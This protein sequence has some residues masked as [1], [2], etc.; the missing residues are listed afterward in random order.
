MGT[1]AESAHPSAPDPHALWPPLARRELLL[2][3]TL[4]LAGLALRAYNVT[5]VGLDHFDE[6]A[7]AYNAVG[8][9]YPGGPRF[10]YLHHKNLS[11]PG[12]Y[13]LIALAYRV[14]GGPSD[15][16]AILPN[17]LLGTLTIPLL[18]AFARRWFG[19]AAGLAAG[20]LVALNEFH[21]RLSRMALTDVAFGLA[22][23]LA[24]ACLAEAVKR[25]SIAWAL[26]AGAATGAAWNTKYHGWLALAVGGAAYALYAWQ[27]RRPPGSHARA[28]LPLG[29]AAGAAGLS[30]LPWALL[31]ELRFGGYRELAARQAR[32][33]SLD[34]LPNA[35][36]QLESQLYFEGGW[37]RASV[38]VALLGALLA[39]SRR[40]ADRRRFPW[41]LALCAASAWIGAA[42]VALLLG[43]LALPGILRRGAPYAHWVLASLF[44]GWLI[45][46]PF[47]H[48]YPRLALPLL[49]ASFLLAGRWM[50]GAAADAPEA[51]R[52]GWRP[53]TLA[54]AGAL[55]AGL[56]W[57]SAAG[58]ERTP[59]DAARDKPRVAARL[60]AELP[61]D[62]RV[63]VVSD[64]ALLFYLHTSGRGRA[65]MDF[66]ERLPPDHDPAKI[67]TYVVEGYQAQ[68]NTLLFRNLHRPDARLV[69]EAR[70]EAGASE[71]VVLDALGPIRGR[72]FL[73]DPD[74]RFEVRLHRYE[75]S[76]APQ[77]APGPAL[78]RA[79]A[80]GTPP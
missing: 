29:I 45:L 41:A 57:P 38:F 35:W 6:G 52:G 7:Y 26:A 22:F 8:L 33:L 18:W 28:L 24:V 60:D 17:V 63:I 10:L 21:V 59:W 31:V 43:L 4:L 56:L 65:V 80:A 12:Y 20:A 9:A 3:A 71:M 69:L 79:G 61:K 30:Y 36:T 34:W 66:P 23:V 55:A 54:L 49:L 68:R 47:Y 75:P 53:P 13:S 64:P 67:R 77:S 5:A 15:T 40:A 27:D 78:G 62:A 72:A 76:A 74:R 16:A 73:R 70:Y 14:H 51:R 37:S 19:P 42:G 58:P 1:A 2:L 44:L 39:G 46:T 50:A 48:P 11:P 32:F 25:Q